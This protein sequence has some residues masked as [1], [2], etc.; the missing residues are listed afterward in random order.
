MLGSP[1][2]GFIISLMP[3]SRRNQDQ[4]QVNRSS[5]FSKRRLT[6]Y[7]KA[8]FPEQPALFQRTKFVPAIVAVTISKAVTIFEAVT[9]SGAVTNITAVAKTSLH[10]TKVSAADGAN[11]NRQELSCYTAADRPVIF[12]PGCFL[13]IRIMKGEEK[14]KRAI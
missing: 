4:T 11:R 6:V 3:E 14:R 12:I 8:H 2:T 1:N 9:V 10:R 5:V 7:S 13:N